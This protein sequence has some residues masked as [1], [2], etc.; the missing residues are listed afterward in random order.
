MSHLIAEFGNK[1]MLW[2]TD[3]AAPLTKLM[4]EPELRDHLRV[5]EGETGASDFDE[6][7]ARVRKQG[8]SS[9]VGITKRTLLLGNRAGDRGRCITTEAEMVSR[10]SGSAG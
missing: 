7:M 8:T 3:A 1:F 10:Y 6:R 2:S 5:L 9:I 4:A